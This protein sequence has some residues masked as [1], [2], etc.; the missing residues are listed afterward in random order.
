VT[1][2][3]IA[4]CGRFGFADR[5]GGDDAG[6]DSGSPSIGLTAMPAMINVGSKSQLVTTGD[7]APTTFTITSGG[8][9]ISGTT[10]IAPSGAGQSTVEAVDAAGARA[11]TTITYDGTQLFVAGGDI[12]GAVAS[13]LRSTDGGATWTQIG[14]LPAPRIN[15]AFV[16][17]DDAMFY[18]GGLDINSVQQRNVY[19]SADG[20]AWA[21]IGLIPVGTAGFTATVYRGEMWIVGGSATTGNSGIPYHSSDGVTWAAAPASIVGR[22]EHDL[23]TT[24]DTLYVLGGHGDTAFLDDIVMTADGTS[25]TTSSSAM[26]IAADF[27]AAGQLAGLT[28]RACGA[29]CTSTET[30]TDMINWTPAAPIPLARNGGSIVGTGGRFVYVG[31]EQSVLRTTDGSAWA[32]IGMLPALRNRTAAVTFTPP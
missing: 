17:Y 13:V 28:L 4:G 14:S 27:P 8:G 19:R 24:R 10:F 16:V 12:A 20:I 3:A 18:M 9:F 26:T 1:L 22:H 15:G 6:G 7:T 11:S 2:V 32:V 29:G 25:W 5:S 31:G 21:N 23:V 30:S